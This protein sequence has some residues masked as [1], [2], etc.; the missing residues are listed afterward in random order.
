MIPENVKQAVFIEKRI[1]FKRAMETAAYINNAEAEYKNGILEVTQYL[2]H[3]HRKIYYPIAVIDNWIVEIE[4]KK[5]S[6]K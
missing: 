2:T 3:G 5:E 1:P 4:V 6:E